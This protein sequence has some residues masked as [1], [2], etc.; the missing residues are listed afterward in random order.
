MS[1]HKHTN[2]LIDETSPYLLQ[3]AHNPVD[4]YPWGEDAFQRSREEDKPIFLSVGYSACHWCHVMEHESFEQE[5]IAASMNE[6][7]VNIKVDREERPDVDEIYMHAVQAMT[8]SGGWPMSVFLT[9]DLEPFYGGTYFPPEDGYGRPGFRNILL[10]VS[11]FYHSRKGE[12]QDRSRK[13]REYLEQA[14]SVRSREGG[15]LSPELLDSAYRTLAGQF[16]HTHGGFG[17][18]PKFPGSMN[19]A[20]FL[21]YYRRTGVSNSLDMVTHSC[22]K[23]GNGGIYDQLGGG[24]HRYSVDARWLVPH[25]EKM[26]Y[27]NALLTQLYLEVYQATG[28]SFFR[29]VVEESLEYVIREMTH[30]EGGFFSTQD[31]DSEGEEGKFFVWTPNEVESV[32][33]ESKGAAFCR[34]FEVTPHGNFEDSKSILNAPEPVENIA[35]LLKME[36]V[37]LEEIIREGRGKLFEDRE[38]RVKPGLDDKIQTSWNS[39]MISSLARASGVLA[40]HRYQTVAEGAAAFL[41]SKLM[42]DG[43]LRHTYKDG[44]ARFNGYLEDYAF[45]ICGLIDLYEATFEVKWLQEAQKLNEIMLEQ[46][47]DEPGGGFFFTSHDHKALLVRSKNPYDNAT[48]SGNSVATHALLRLGALT[49]RQDL[50]KK[51]ERVLNL[52]RDFMEG[53]PGGFSHMLCALDLY[54]QRPKEIAIVGGRDQEDTKELL[55]SV[56]GRLLPNKVICLRDPTDS[57]EVTKVIP[58]LEGKTQKDGRATAYVCKNFT[59]SAPVTEAGELETLLEA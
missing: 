39:L 13:L 43:R 28:E 40:D 44:R 1:D 18:A 55:S 36:A 31:A 8:G 56:H 25:F 51:G 16:D 29:R 10:S 50:W 11:Q 19:L 34:Y 41:L 35:R 37:S 58:L 33:G 45:L 2:R 23:M 3:H 6:H 53:A 47:W 15:V 20:F 59:C 46:F 30:P 9:P 22:R 54:I 7:F 42:K 5:A 49:G 21:R 14:A 4:W 12:V 48:P 27:D 52:F 38:N 17:S 57:Q 26:L 32:L 24:F